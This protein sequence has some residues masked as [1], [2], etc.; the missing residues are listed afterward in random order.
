MTN[1]MK[2][3]RKKQKLVKSDDIAH[4][5][6]KSA[7]DDATHRQKQNLAKLTVEK[8]KAHTSA[9]N[10]SHHSN[11]TNQNEMLAS[12]H[13]HHPDITAKPR[14]RERYAEHSSSKGSSDDQQLPNKTSLPSILKIA[15]DIDH[16]KTA[17]AAA[18][19]LTRTKLSEYDEETGKQKHAPL[20][21]IICDRFIIGMEKHI[22][23]SH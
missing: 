13:D 4:E 23:L 10:D 2:K 5:D 18:K 15:G 20:V 3:Y 14:G 12:N 11:S 16:V 9:S 17:E 7:Q 19:A 6:T 22:L 21:C 1:Y 8:S